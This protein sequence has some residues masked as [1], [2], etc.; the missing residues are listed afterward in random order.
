MGSGASSF[1]IS[2]FCEGPECFLIFF[3]CCFLS[4]GD[5]HRECG[6]VHFGSDGEVLSLGS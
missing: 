4:L 3:S 6:A 2:R 5:S 1:Q